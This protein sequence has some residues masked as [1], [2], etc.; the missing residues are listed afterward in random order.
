MRVEN[1]MDRARHISEALVVA[2]TSLSLACSANGQGTLIY[3]QQS[4]TESDLGG[5]GFAIQS[6]QPMGQSF[7][8]SLDGVG[9]IRLHL[10]RGTFNQGAVI[11]LNLMTDSITGAVLAATSPVTLPV[12][13]IGTADFLFPNQIPLTPGTTYYFRPII[14]SGGPFSLSGDTFRYPG[15]SAFLNG[16]AVS[17][18]LWFR[19]GIIVPE[20]STAALLLIG[21][22]AVAYVRR[23]S[24]SKS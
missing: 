9:F 14:Q 20:P 24:K 16:N 12:G 1:E 5:Q 10:V 13:F 17:E 23:K 22:S 2:M 18:D 15:G 4:S 7:T 19:E 3:D 11:F 8:P 6:F 21:G